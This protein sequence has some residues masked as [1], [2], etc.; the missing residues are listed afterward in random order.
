[1]SISI[2]YMVYQNS[3]F[4]YLLAAT[5]SSVPVLCKMLNFRCLFWEQHS[6]FFL[7]NNHIKSEAFQC[8]CFH[9]CDKILYTFIIVNMSFITLCGSYSFPSQNLCKFWTHSSEILEG[10]TE[11]NSQGLFQLHDSVFHN[12]CK[13]VAKVMRFP[14]GFLTLRISTTESFTDHFLLTYTVPLWN[15]WI[16]VSTVVRSEIDQWE[17]PCHFKGRC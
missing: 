14:R 6:E 1:M 15:I 10:E 13:P 2:C 12:L 17:F 16:T 8:Q 7:L 4:N 11:F 9:H 3:V 5:C